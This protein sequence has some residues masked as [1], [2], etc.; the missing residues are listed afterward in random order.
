MNLGS[1]LNSLS[2]MPTDWWLTALAL[3]ASLNAATHAGVANGMVI[4]RLVGGN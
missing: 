4:G 2:R 3:I 1:L